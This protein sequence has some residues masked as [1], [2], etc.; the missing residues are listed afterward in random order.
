VIRTRLLRPLAARPRLII[1][2]G[3]GAFVAALLPSPLVWSERWMAGWDAGVLVFLALLYSSWLKVDA[4]AMRRR[5]ER[6]DE[7]RNV[8]FWP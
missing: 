6:D 3:V 4:A 1:A 5:A 8:S 2:L 7:G